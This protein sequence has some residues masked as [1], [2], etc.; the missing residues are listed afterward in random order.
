MRLIL[1][2][3]LAL[4]LSGCGFQLRGATPLSPP[5]KRLYIETANPYG[6]LTRNLRDYLKTSGV[7]LT[8]TR[9]NALTVLHIMNENQAQQLLSVS[10][11]QQ[12]RQYSLTL[13]V[14][15]E[16]TAPNRKVLMPATTVV[17]SRLLTSLSD[18]ILGSSNEQSTLYQQMRL[19]IVYDIMNRLGSRDVTTLLTETPKKP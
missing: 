17:E 5:L 9:E 6:A 7:E 18:Q 15:F 8:D 11:L 2:C 16:I 10:G 3:F 4:A 19:A 13:S 14:T 12:T 1:I